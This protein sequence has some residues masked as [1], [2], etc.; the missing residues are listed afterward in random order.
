MHLKLEGQDRDTMLKE[1][2]AVGI[3]SGSRGKVMKLRLTAKE[4]AD[5]ETLI[6]KLVAECERQSR[7]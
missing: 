7:E 3:Y 5:H 1:L 2:E 4:L 6:R